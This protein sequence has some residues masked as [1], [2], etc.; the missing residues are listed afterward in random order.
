[1]LLFSSTSK[2]KISRSL[3]SSNV[4]SNGFASRPFNLWWLCSA[5]PANLHPCPVPTGFCPPTTDNSKTA[6]S[7]KMVACYATAFRCRPI[8]CRRNRTRLWYD[9]KRG[10]FRHDLIHRALDQ[11]PHTSQ[12]CSAIDAVYGAT[13]PLSRKPSSDS[14]LPLGSPRIPRRLFHNE[15][16]ALPHILEE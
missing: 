1:M 5:T 3:P 8:E 9:K 7:K 4:S 13:L 11:I 14:D 15:W 2:K 10:S 6:G 16:K 12:R